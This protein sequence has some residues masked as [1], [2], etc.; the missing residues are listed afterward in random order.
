MGWP[1]AEVSESADSAGFHASAFHLELFQHEHAFRVFNPLAAGLC[2]SLGAVLTPHALQR[3]I[4]L[5]FLARHVL[6]CPHLHV[7]LRR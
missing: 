1:T 3:L 2:G 7:G 4:R 5:A 6:C